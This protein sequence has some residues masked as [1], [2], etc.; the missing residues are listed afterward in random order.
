MRVYKTGV[1]KDCD[2]GRDEGRGG[3]KGMVAL[4][5]SAAGGG[6]RGDQRLGVLPRTVRAY[7]CEHRKASFGSRPGI[8][9]L[10]YACRI[11][12]T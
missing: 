4:P 1:A 9:M 5:S 3:R 10:L 11:K 7:Y 8:R 12:R 2:P 6:E